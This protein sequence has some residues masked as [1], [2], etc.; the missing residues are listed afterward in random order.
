MLGYAELLRCGAYGAV[1]DEQRDPLGQ[2]VNS[3][4]YLTSLVN[5]LLDEAQIETRNLSLNMGLFSLRAVLWAVH[6][7]MVVLA[8]NKGLNFELEIDAAMPD[9]L[10]GDEKRVQQ[11]LVNLCSN[12]IKF[13][14]SGGVGIRVF[15]PSPLQWATQVWD[16][17]A[18]IPKESRDEIFMPFR[19]LNNSI[20]RENRGTGLGLSIVKQIVEIMGGS[21]Q[22][23][24]E[25]GKG[26]K[27]TIVLPFMP[28]KEITV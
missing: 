26:S 23:E 4:N 6:D 24:S 11:I 17:G 3:A 14:K 12:A 5:D 7:R 1:S 19:Q 20:T 2:I 27:F 21:I 9:Q 22:L 28:Q 25:L 18:G 16:T 10:Y 8:K 13:T 15:Q